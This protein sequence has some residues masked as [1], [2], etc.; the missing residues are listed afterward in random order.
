MCNGG[1]GAGR[2][3]GGVQ[4]HLS[5]VLIMVDAFPEVAVLQLFS[6]DLRGRSRSESNQGARISSGI[7]TCLSLLHPDLLLPD[8]MLPV[9]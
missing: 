1:V 7:V 5:A 8:H 6:Q 3:S 9:L 4:T 2:E